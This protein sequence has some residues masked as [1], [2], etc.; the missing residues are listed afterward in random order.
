MTS[1]AAH[2]SGTLRLRETRRRAGMSWPPEPLT[3][4]RRR[5][6]RPPLDSERETRRLIAELE[7]LG[8]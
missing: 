6:F 7:A 8:H 5:L 3:R 2:E 4:T 1:L